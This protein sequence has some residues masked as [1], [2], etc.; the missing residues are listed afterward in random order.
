MVDVLRSKGRPPIGGLWWFLAGGDNL[1]RRVD[2]CYYV[3]TVERPVSNSAKDNE[4]TKDSDERM[5]SLAL[6]ASH[7]VPHVRLHRDGIVGA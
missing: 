1:C 4:H 7:D 2:L 5:D 6:R 3:S